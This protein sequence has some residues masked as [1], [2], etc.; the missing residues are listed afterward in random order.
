[1]KSVKIELNE[2]LAH[3]NSPSS[4]SENKTKL[5]EGRGLISSNEESEFTKNGELQGGYTANFTKSDTSGP[6]KESNDSDSKFQLRTGPSPGDSDKEF[7][8][9]NFGF[10]D[11]KLGRRDSKNIGELSA[12]NTG[13]TNKEFN[14]KGSG[15]IHNSQEEPKK[16]YESMAGFESIAETHN[17]K[18]NEGSGVN[19]FESILDGQKESTLTKD[20]NFESFVDVEFDTELNQIVESNVSEVPRN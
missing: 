19:V 9:K 6:G 12:R 16:V 11:D 20:I 5:S 7:N 18:L 14:K 4:F 3:K 15:T 13:G 17:V 2:V 1:M 10:T 8:G